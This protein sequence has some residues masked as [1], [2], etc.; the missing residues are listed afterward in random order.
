MDVGEIVRPVGLPDRRPD[1]RHGSRRP[2]DLDRVDHD[3][4]ISL[5]EEFLHEVDAAD[6]D[7]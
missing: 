1:D 4:R 7:V 2:I 6:A 3:Q 5:I